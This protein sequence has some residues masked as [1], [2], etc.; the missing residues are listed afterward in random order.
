[1]S[2]VNRILGNATQVNPTEVRSEIGPLLIPGEEVVAA[3]KL[4]RDMVIFTQQRLIW[5]DVQGI[6]GS[7]K[8]YD[9]ILFRSITRFSIETAGTFDLDAELKIWVS[10]GGAAPLVFNFKR[11]SSLQAI[12][13]L[14]AHSIFGAAFAK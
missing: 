5:V 9:S 2:L 1:M 6:T 3:F 11:G 8:S 12:Q 13:Q 10:G 4:V 14:L 7:K